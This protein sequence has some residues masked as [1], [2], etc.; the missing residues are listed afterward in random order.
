[1]RFTTSL[2]KRQSSTVAVLCGVVVSMASL[3]HAPLLAA[4]GGE[5]IYRIA[6]TLL[7]FTHVPSVSQKATLRGILDEHTTTVAEQVLAQALLNV[8]HIA[9]PDDKPKLEA[10]IR[11]ESAT[12]DIKTLAT[13]LDKLTH[14]PTEADKTKLRQ[15]LQ[16][17]C[18]RRNQ[19]RRRAKT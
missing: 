8:E 14:T 10:L 9:S 17:V 3:N 15:L 2:S 5:A 12:P 4:D 1:M 18:K 16:Q 19:S 11:D 6:K 7:D 13:I